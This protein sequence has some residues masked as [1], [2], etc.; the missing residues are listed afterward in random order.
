[1]NSRERMLAAMQ[2]Q[3][4]DRVP[5]L[6][7]V[8]EE[9]V[10]LA[11]L[12]REGS[13]AVQQEEWLGKGPLR[14]GFRPPSGPGYHALEVVENL[15]LD[16]LGVHFYLPDL[17]IKKVIEGRAMV[18]GGEIHSRADLGKI[19]LPD[20]DDPALYEPLRR[21]VEKYRDTGLALFCRVPLGADPVI[22]G[23]GF[24]GFSYALY[25][26]YAMLEALFDLYT[27][28]YARAMRHICA[29]DFDFIWSGEDIAHK[30]GPFLSPKMFQKL[31][32]PYYRRVADQI[33]KPW[34]FHSDGNLMPVVDDLLSLGLNGLHPIEPGPMDLAEM[35]RRYGSQLCL[36]GHINVD[37]LSRGTPEEIDCLV[38]EA[39]A[40][41][42]PGGGY[43]AGSSNSVT[44]YCRPENVR[45][46]AQAIRNYGKY[47][48]RLV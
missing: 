22:L 28:W 30:T 14:T 16:A 10:A 41:A 35:K 39:I 19:Q 17:S 46:M 25:D 20:A 43:I 37:T 18:V 33:S 26:D 6:E 1:M 44:S 38:K 24:E 9:P 47:P 32:M 7:S 42:G 45:A 23:M 31:F 3:E 34:I 11:L 40:V 27:G 4:P 36:C 8:V 15:G 29:I 13:G 5:F 2:C 48:L 12:D 21:F